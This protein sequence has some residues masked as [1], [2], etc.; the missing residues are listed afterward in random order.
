M[1][2]AQTSQAVT[3][4]MKQ[5]AKSSQQT[6]ESSRQ[7]SH[8][9]RNTVEIAE[10]LQH[11]VGGFKIV[12]RLELYKLIGLAKLNF[13]GNSFISAILADFGEFPL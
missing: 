11:S 13:Q 12:L 2:Q 8:S 4:L 3:E 1:S 5:L 7:V 9:L 10:Q 6:S